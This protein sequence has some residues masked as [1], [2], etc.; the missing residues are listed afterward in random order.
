MSNIESKTYLLG[1]LVEPKTYTKVIV[2]PEGKLEKKTF[3]LEARRIPLKDIRIRLYEE[4]FKSGLL[5]FYLIFSLYLP[6]ISKFEFTNLN[7]FPIKF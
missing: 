5:S 1:E 2:T 7:Q 4:H 6:N 3:T